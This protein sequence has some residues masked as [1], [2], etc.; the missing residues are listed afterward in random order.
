MESKKERERLTQRGKKK[1]RTTKFLEVICFDI[2]CKE[3]KSEWVAIVWGTVCGCDVKVSISLCWRYKHNNNN[4]KFTQVIAVKGFHIFITN[5]YTWTIATYIH[6]E[7]SSTRIQHIIMITMYSF[8][9]FGTFSSKWKRKFHK[10]TIC[11][12]EPIHTTIET[13]SHF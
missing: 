1:Y 7:S 9:L 12:L 13:H 6:V 3:S 2:G 4:N 5:K 8:S 11:S 10:S